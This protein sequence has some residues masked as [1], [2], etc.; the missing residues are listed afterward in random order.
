MQIDLDL[1]KTEEFST[2][3]EYLL[4]ETEISQDNEGGKKQP[5]TEGNTPDSCI[6]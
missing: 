3:K 5:W 6:V 4:A 2:P 1:N